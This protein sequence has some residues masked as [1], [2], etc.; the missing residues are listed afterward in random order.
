MLNRIFYS[1]GIRM[2]MAMGLMMF[3][4]ILSVFNHGESSSAKASNP[5]SK[6]YV[7]SS[8]T[9]S[10]STHSSSDS[11]TPKYRWVDKRTGLPATQE[12]IDDE[13]Y[14]RQVLHEMRENY[15]R[16]HGPVDSSNMESPD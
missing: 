1:L 6:D 11:A 5:W 9:S 3:A 13:A 16:D 15:E 4:G 2:V 7:A 10:S 8:S 14:R 12:Q